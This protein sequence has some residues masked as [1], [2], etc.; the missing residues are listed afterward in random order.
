MLD[1]RKEM[2]AP[3]AWETLLAIDR[4]RVSGIGVAK[5]L[6]F[7]K[8]SRNLSAVSLSNEHDFTKI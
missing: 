5:N 3:G 8:C 7:A 1:R 2:G 6:T 4:G